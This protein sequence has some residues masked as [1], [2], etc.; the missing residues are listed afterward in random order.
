VHP[1]SIYSGFGGDGDTGFLGS[2]IAVFG[3]IVLRSPKTGA[4]TQVLL[5]SSTAPR[6]ATTTGGYWSHGRRWRAS[7][8]ARS[9]TEQRWLWEESTRLVERTS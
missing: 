8:P 4:K 5:A 2:L 1:G 7:R 9:R 3:R 6:V